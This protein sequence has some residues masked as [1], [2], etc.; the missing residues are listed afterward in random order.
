MQNFKTFPKEDGSNPW[1]ALSSYREVA[2]TS[3]DQ[4]KSHYDYIIVGAGFGGIAAALQLAEQRP[5]AKIAIFDALSVGAYSSGRNAGFISQTQL[6]KALVGFHRYKLSDH[7]LLSHLNRQAVARMEDLI[8]THHLH[9]QWRHDGS[10]RAVRE[11]QNLPALKELAALYRRLGAQIEELEGDALSER[12]GTDF[13]RSGIYLKDTIL[14]NPSELIRGLASTLLDRVNIF[15]HIKVTA[16]NSGPTPSVQLEN[17]LTVSASKVI[18]TISAFV[19]E[20]GGLNSSRVAAIHSFGA[21]TRQLSES[22]FAPFKDLKP[23]GLTATHP[24]G[25]TVRFTPYRRI[26]IRTKIRFAGNLILPGQQLEKA[27]FELTRAFV[28]RFPSLEGVNF[29]YLYGGLISFTGNALPLFGEIKENIYAAATSDGAGV[30]R[31]FILG[32]YLADLI[33]GRESKELSY[34]KAHYIPSYLPPEPL[35]TL[36]ARTALYFKDRKA[37]SEL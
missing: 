3:P 4:I 33:L 20:Q 37:G 25:A 11:E 12:L 10:Y 2:F 1:E 18:L 14:D 36:G 28:R 24:S 30:A 19:R 34:L 17:L 35:R 27:R 13:Y 15:E 16:V 31:A 6:T 23:W 9:V 8:D 7:A 32:T 22:E 21:M 5:E 26:F 29:E